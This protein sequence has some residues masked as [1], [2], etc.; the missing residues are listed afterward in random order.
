MMNELIY[1]P[2][3]QIEGILSEIGVG[4]IRGSLEKTTR[5]EDRRYLALQP[6]FFHDPRDENGE[7]P[8]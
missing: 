7:V 3:N 1:G 8:F 4:Q 6:D 5:E 2:S